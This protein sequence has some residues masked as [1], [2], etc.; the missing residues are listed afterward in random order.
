MSAAAIDLD[1]IYRLS[2]DGDYPEALDL[3][4]WFVADARDAGD[5]DAIERALADVDVS[6]L[7]PE[8][9]L[10]FAVATYEMRDRLTGRPSLV[11]RVRE[12]LTALGHDPDECK[13]R[14]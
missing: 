12:R 9:A 11:D 7:G 14:L 1:A 8:T 13:G 2:T 10:G 4:F 6:R 3:V 5:L